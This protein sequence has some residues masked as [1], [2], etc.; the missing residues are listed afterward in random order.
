[1]IH[2][3]FVEH[4]YSMWFFMPLWAQTAFAGLALRDFLVFR[5]KPLSHL[6][7]G[8]LRSKCDLDQVFCDGLEALGFSSIY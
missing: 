7:R 2:Q 6:D 1:L 8:L 3:G 5:K 4:P